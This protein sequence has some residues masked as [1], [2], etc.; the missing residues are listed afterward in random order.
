MSEIKVLEKLREWASQHKGWSYYDVEI[1]EIA[2]EI[3]H[4]ITVL[5]ECWAQEMREHADDSVILAELAL[6]NAEL[7]R[8]IAEKYMELP[9][10][11]D[12]MPI[13]VGDEI[14]D[15]DSIPCIV[16]S[17]S[18]TRVYCKDGSWVYPSDCYHSTWR[19][20]MGKMSERTCKNISDD[21][22]WFKCSKCKCTCSIDYWDG[23][24]GLPR[25]CP[26]CGAKCSER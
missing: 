4:E 12:G 2:D 21:P 13:H 26:S 11:A 18:A 16:T 3:E 15:K 10:D 6:E 1:N 24:L 20:L 14:T 8:K 19:E 9:V 23:G 17:V 7:K 5:Q 22:C 25:F